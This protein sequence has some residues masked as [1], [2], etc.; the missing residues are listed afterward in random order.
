MTEQERDP[1]S[2]N[3]PRGTVSLYL[4]G[5]VVVLLVLLILAIL[6]AA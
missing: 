5:I 2:V 3:D 6:R 1:G 4:M